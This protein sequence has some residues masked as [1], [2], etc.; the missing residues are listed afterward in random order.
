MSPLSETRAF[1]IDL[2]NDLLDQTQY[3]IP[4]PLG[5]SLELSEVDILDTGCAKG[6]D[7]D[8]SV[9]GND[10]EIALHTSEGALE[11]KVVGSACSI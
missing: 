6:I 1:N 8:R 4:D 5:I 11:T 10:V 3:W 2:A 9:V 7:L